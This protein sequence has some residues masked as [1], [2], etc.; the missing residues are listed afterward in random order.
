MARRLAIALTL[1]AGSA[2]AHGLDADQLD[3]RLAGD[4]VYLTATPSVGA[5]GAFDDDKNGLLRAEEVARHRPEILAWFERNLRLANEYAQGGE[6]IFRDVS[7]PHAFD[8]TEPN[9]ASHLRFTFRYRWGERPS[10]LRVQ[11]HAA[12]HQKLRVAAT[13]VRPEKTLPAQEPI[14]ATESV[15]LEPLRPAHVFFGTMVPKTEGDDPPAA[16]PGPSKAWLLVLALAVG[17]LAWVLRS[18]RQDDVSG[19]SASPKR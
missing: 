8:G 12:Q 7:T 9:G 14:G 17:V 10:A 1:V 6:G 19:G 4:T 15:L 3:L 11:W 16:T 2:H 13:R 5:L 18:L